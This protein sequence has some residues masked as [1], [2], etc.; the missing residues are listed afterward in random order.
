MI[1]L[2][3]GLAEILHPHSYHKQTLCENLNPIRFIRTQT[4]KPHKRLG[5][6]LKSKICYSARINV[7]GLTI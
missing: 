5:K 7:T 3:F 4:L 1:I 2:L 6:S